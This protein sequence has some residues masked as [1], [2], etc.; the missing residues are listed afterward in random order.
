MNKVNWIIIQ[1]YKK[2]AYSPVRIMDVVT[3][4]EYNTQISMGK[5]KPNSICLYLLGK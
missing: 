1:K 4:D 3:L 2:H 5:T